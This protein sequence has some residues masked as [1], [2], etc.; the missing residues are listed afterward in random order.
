L[1]LF[2]W[3]ASFAANA[4]LMIVSLAI[5]AINWGVFY[6]LAT[7]VRR[8]PELQTNAVARTRIH[9]LGGLLWAVS[10]A[11][12]S[13]FALGAGPARES[14]LILACAGAMATF[15][16]LS[17]ALITLLI[18]APLACAGPLI[19]LYLFPDTQQTATFTS[20]ALALGM[21]LSFLVNRILERQY[22]LTV[23]RDRLVS[24][25][26]DAA[27]VNGRLAKSKSALIATLSHEIRNGLAGVTHVLAAA[28]GVSSRSTPSREQLRAA[29]EASRDLAEV[30]DATLDTETAEAGQLSVAIEPFDP[31]R[32]VRDLAYLAQPLAA[33][34]GLELSV[35]VDPGLAGGAVLA[36]PARTRQIVSNLMGNALKY[37][38]RG[39]VELRVRREDESRARFEIADTGPGLTPEEV[40]LAFEPFARIE[41]TSAGSAGAGLGLSLAR[42]LAALMNGEVG[43]VSAAGA[44]SCFWL[45]LAYDPA[46][47]VSHDPDMDAQPSSAALFVLSVV[48]NR[49]EAANLRVTLE[50]LGHQVIQAQRSDRALDLLKIGK[51]DVIVAS[52]PETIAALRAAGVG[53]PILALT[54]GDPEMAAACQAAGC[55]GILRP[56]LS[57][58]A[59]AR[60][61]ASLDF[62]KLKAANAA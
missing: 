49:L 8:K 7:T 25:F 17:P 37:T 32:L 11:Q 57:A 40:A 47:K 38:A 3:T 34:K 60:Q 46:A 29:L 10:I 13:A 55:A 31:A 44:G 51:I 20:G 35:F 43:V 9:V 24:A 12:I 4:P 53:E 50:D 15:F 54:D 45:D 39:R 27:N 16:F 42:S 59:V 21:A 26:E 22:A 36:D 62:R 52:T 58:T 56:P 23:E 28:A 41:R 19:C 18:V 1:L 14:I 48:E 6:V 61:L 33:A 2:A 5:F 30:L